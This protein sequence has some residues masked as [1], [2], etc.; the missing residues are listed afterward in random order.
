MSEVRRDG[1]LIDKSAWVVAVGLAAAFA[2]TRGA[3]RATVVRDGERPL[4]HHASAGRARTRAS[5]A[6]DA[7]S[8]FDGPFATAIREGRPAAAAAKGGQA[9]V[10]VQCPIVP[11]VDEH[12]RLLVAN[13]RVHTWIASG[14]WVRFPAPECRDDHRDQGK[15]THVNI[16][17]RRSKAQ[18]KQV[19]RLEQ[20]EACANALRR[21]TRRLGP[22][23]DAIAKGSAERHRPPCGDLTLRRKSCVLERATSRAKAP[24]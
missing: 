19:K 18:A 23:D 16:L 22:A 24:K 21:S 10:R 15:A 17:R 12:G 4:T 2:G 6:A 8:L 20:T 1:L 9:K 3:H 14:A 5:P 11:R 7:V 13:R